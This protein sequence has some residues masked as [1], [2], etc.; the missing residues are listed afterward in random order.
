M[1]SKSDIETWVDKYTPKLLQ[2]AMQKLG[3]KDLAM[4]LVQDTFLVAFEKFDSF[5]GN[6]QAL[7]WLF[8]IL[9]N[10]INDY[11][12]KSSRLGLQ[13]L[14]AESYADEL[15]T[16]E[17]YWAKNQQFSE[18]KEEQHL[19][20]NPDFLK[21]YELCMGHLPTHWRDA[22]LQKY[23]FEK[24]SK[25]IC[26]VLNISDTNYWQIIHRAKLL[27]RNCLEKSWRA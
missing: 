23:I 11:F 7:T 5:Q 17:G 25:E 24:D 1:K 4:D 14:A 13:P 6:S 2:W 20:D 19:L 10:K 15:F 27:M 16:E 21:I 3:D 8:G 9:N 18:W 26:Q 12:K 22:L